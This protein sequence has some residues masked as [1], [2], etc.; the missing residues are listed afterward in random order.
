MCCHAQ[1]IQF[2]RMSTVPY[3][4][5]ISTIVPT[6]S[7]TG[8]F[9]I[10]FRLFEKDAIAVYVEN[11]L[12]SPSAYRVNASF[13]DGYDD[14]ATMTLVNPTDDVV[15]IEGAMIPQ[16]GEQYIPT[17]PSVLQKINNEMGRL[18]ATI[19]E[20]RREAN[21]S[22]RSVDG[23]QVVKGLDGHVPIFT[24]SG[25]AIGPRVTSLVD[26]IQFAE[27][28]E[29]AAFRA[30]N[31]LGNTYAF[32]PF[33]S[34]AEIAA[35]TIPGSTKKLSATING[36]SLEWQPDPAGTAITDAAG[37]KFTPLGDAYPE[38]F[39]A[40][41][42]GVTDDTAACQAWADFLRTNGRNGRMN[43]RSYLVTS[44]QMMPTQMYGITG[45]NF[46]KSEFLIANSSRTAVGLNFGHVDGN[47]R[48]PAGVRL[49]NI[50]VRA[51]SGTKACLVQFAR[52]IDLQ[53]SRLRIAG[54]HGATGI[55]AYG[56]WNCDFSEITVYG[57]GHNI[58]MK[59]VPQG[60]TF[61][62]ANGG[63]TLTSN[64]DIFDAGD[65]GRNI[66]LNSPTNSGGQMHTITAVTGPRTA[67]VSAPQTMMAHTASFGN[68]GGIRG[69]TT[70]GDNKLTL[71]AAYLT[72]DDVGR[73]VY[74]LAGR[75]NPASEGFI[76]LRAR[77]TAVAGAVATL[78]VTTPIT[79]GWVDLVFDPAVDLGEP[80]AD[81][82][83]QKTNDAVFSD[84]HVELHRGCGMVLY[85]TRVSL[86]RLKLH[87]Y[88]ITA[89]SGNNE[90]A[91]NIQALIYATEG[92]IDGHFDQAVC[93]NT[94]RIVMQD[95]LNLQFN[96][97][98]TLGINRLPLLYTIGR[99]TAPAYRSRI[100]VGS[101][102]FYGND[103]NST[104]DGM[105]GEGWYDQ[106][107]TTTCASR[108]GVAKKHG[109][110]IV[111]L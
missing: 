4:P 3:T 28:A 97:M 63:T 50:R 79:R 54:H 104:F 92:T 88:N 98:A 83:N 34:H 27:R 18:W 95:M 17:D 38:H 109:S 73:V 29:L 108:P 6:A 8:P 30:E 48:P 53:V 51:A 69:S 20:L 107:G 87:G 65:V 24:E 96:Y 94:G 9:L 76:P 13:A 46:Q 10:G 56:L 100:P 23:G 111:N 31:A 12:L 89:L 57:C 103:A 25:F 45:D 71:S 75:Q 7:T 33:A 72:A 52:S 61:A 58:P 21:R 66:T 14:A 105:I 19:I 47:T 86:P 49:D 15:R 5:R 93:G 77:I 106:Y 67:T 62:I 2:L 22:L 36:L 39:G 43:S 40:I 16:R 59:T 42:D 84:L 1:G 44:L 74:I 35:A 32:V 101:I 102:Q 60:T 68:F 82:L 41:G 80:D 37:S 55:R 70:A 11:Q 64:V 91:T 26:P 110:P 81:Q 99:S 85:G 90:Q 78:D